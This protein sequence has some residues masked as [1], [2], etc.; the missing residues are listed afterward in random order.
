M[1]NPINWTSLTITVL[2]AAKIVLEAFNVD[3]INDD[4]I[5][6]IAN[7]VAAIATIVGVFMSHRKKGDNI[8]GL[9]SASLERAE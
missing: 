3:V 9:I 6:N 4:M 8:D 2:G 1:Q 5:N 7:G